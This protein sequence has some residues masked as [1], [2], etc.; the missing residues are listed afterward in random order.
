MFS[1]QESNNLASYIDRLLQ[2]DRT[3]KILLALQD[4][5]LLKYLTNVPVE[6]IPEVLALLNEMA[7]GIFALHVGQSWNFENSMC[8]A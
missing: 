4:K 1:S 6:L 8:T 3:D 2:L 5:S 7:I